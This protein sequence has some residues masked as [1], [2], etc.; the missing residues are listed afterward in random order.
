MFRRLALFYSVFVEDLTR[1]LLAFA[2]P[3]PA[4]GLTVLNGALRRRF[5]VVACDTQ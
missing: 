3:L 4:I 2:L 1:E 5:T